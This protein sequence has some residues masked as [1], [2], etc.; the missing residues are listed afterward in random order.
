MRYAV[1]DVE[2]TGLNPR[3]DRVVEMAC[4][5]IAG[6]RIVR[7]WSTLVDPGCPIPERATRVHGI[8]D[9]D[10][11]AAPPFRTAQRALWRL[12]TGHT[13]V[14]HNARFDFGFLPGLQNLPWLC[15]LALARRRFP[16]AP[17]F[18]CQTLREYLGIP[19]Q[20]A[21]RALGDALVTADIL[22]RC[23]ERGDERLTA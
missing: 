23:L 3:L 14:A 21:H 19:P 2:T 7:T 13:V 22:L 17:N 20:R 18:R 4:V 11:A 5:Q 10:V 1:V 15:T 9:A 16:N 12:C 8:R 6:G